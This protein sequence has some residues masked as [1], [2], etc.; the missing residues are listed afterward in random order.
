MADDHET[1]RP[2][3][4]REWTDGRVTFRRGDHVL[5]TGGP[6][7]GLNGTIE[8]LFESDA[9]VKLETGE[10]AKIEYRHLLSSPH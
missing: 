3:E 10:L 7:F 2:W 9:I 1:K 8:E 5:N 4:V 6:H